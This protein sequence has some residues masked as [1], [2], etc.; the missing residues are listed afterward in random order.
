MK[1]ITIII[2][3]ILFV[4]GMTLSA[5]AADFSWTIAE[6]NKYVD[7]PGTAA[8][9]ALDGDP[10][11]YHDGKNLY[12]MYT[13]GNNE[14]KRYIG[15][16]MEDLREQPDSELIGFIQPHGDDRYWM[17]GMWADETTGI[18]YT[19]VHVEFN[20]FEGRYHERCIRYAT[21][22]DKGATWTLQDII[23][24][25][26]HP[27]FSDEFPGRYEGFGNADQK[28]FVDTKS[29]YAYIY[30]MKAW[31]DKETGYQWKTWQVA[32]SPISEKFK[33]GTWQKWYKGEWSQ[34]GI[35]GHDTSLCSA[36]STGAFVFYSTYL[37]R[38]VMLGMQKEH[39]NSFIST[40]TDLNK[41]DWTVPQKFLDSSRLGWYSWVMD[42]NTWS[43]THI[44]K[45]F[46]F[47]TAS[48]THRPPMY[49]NMSFG[50]GEMTEEDAPYY[51]PD[52]STL[53]GSICDYNDI[54]DFV[55]EYAYR[56]DF[57]GD[58]EKWKK[59]EGD[60]KFVVEKQQK[61]MH[62]SVCSGDKTVFSPEDAPELS[63]CTIEYTVRLN[64]CQ[65]FGHVFGMKDGKYQ[66][67]E[68][69]N[70][71]F[72]LVDVDGTRTKL[73]DFLLKYIE[74]TAY[75]IKMV[76][77]SERVT[78]IINDNIMYDDVVSGFSPKKG[79]FGMMAFAD[80]AVDYDDIA[81]YD[82]IYVTI[83]GVQ[84]GF[85]TK[86]CLVNGY[87]MVPFRKIF[88]LFG[89]DISYD[90]VKNK[91]K[92][93]R[94]EDT[95]IIDGNSGA[96]NVNGNTSA[97]P[98]AVIENGRVL[99]P[100][101]VIT[102]T[103]G[104]SVNWHGEK[105]TVAIASNGGLKI[106]LPQLQPM[107]LEEFQ[108]TSAI[109]VIDNLNRNMAMCRMEGSVKA[110]S[111]TR[112]IFDIRMRL[113][114]T[115][116]GTAI[117][118]YYEQNKFDIEDIKIR[119]YSEGGR[120][121]ELSV[122]VSKDGKKWVNI[123]MRAD[124]DSVFDPNNVGM[125]FVN[126]VSSQKID[127]G[128]KYARIRITA[129]NNAWGAQLVKVELNGDN[130]RNYLESLSTEGF[131][132]T[133][134]NTDKIERMSDDFISETVDNKVFNVSK[135]IYR[136][137]AVSETYLIYNTGDETMNNFR[138]V[139]RTKGTDVKDYFD[140]YISQDCEKWNKT[141]YTVNR[142]VRDDTSEQMYFSQVDFNADD[143]YSYVKIV[144]KAV[145]ENWASQLSRV[146]MN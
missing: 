83:D 36:P 5:S 14:W 7:I 129:G 22:S 88:E 35:G 122:A 141:D 44:G 75:R 11:I 69:D 80:N 130:V 131:V 97:V 31:N 38:Y 65:K 70:G 82:G 24:S 118:R 56:E 62:L 37:N 104:A 134:K 68:Y 109:G 142:T 126:V 105:N 133:L 71:E 108:D 92:A 32:R 120:T 95:I 1:K 28:L 94:G 143:G 76:I 9:S 54:I 132:D 136:K 86:P 115:N 125:H 145:N 41:Q 140:I 121:S 81:V 19:T 53:K 4:A 128:M 66:S 123:P 114:P 20:Y 111:D 99:V 146:E 43:R 119:L 47:Y 79:T 137:S 73:F 6:E 27:E 63:D 57:S 74:N 102:E 8:S 100:V 77:Q 23:L 39:N 106:K 103:F 46:R 85:D 30:Y 64:D 135:S 90:E 55:P 101:R 61:Q 91:I 67:F 58:V 124:G 117:D 107:K 3:F 93:T 40:C 139:V 50:E 110:I 45:D 49:I 42:T 72:S 84:I 78:V 113:Y 10:A 59:T 33:A 34:P 96:I 144:F 116:P 12:F 13:T 138:A 15:T 17:C 52:Y 112:P 21:S 51:Y 29:G 2:C 18:W 98:N 26:D 48:S 60:G 87:T 89:A 127:S 25:G 16:S